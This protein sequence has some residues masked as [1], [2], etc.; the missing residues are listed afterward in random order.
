M[1][2]YL[3]VAKLSKNSVAQKYMY[4]A[5][6]PIDAVRELVRACHCTSSL[7]IY[8]Y[9]ILEILEGGRYIP[10]SAKINSDVINFR[11]QEPATVEEA[12]VIPKED[13]YDPYQLASI[14]A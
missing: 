10:V 13:S 9:D 1:P 11:S 2:N 3:A 5:A 12:V 7:E 8:E 6:D 14:K 4:V